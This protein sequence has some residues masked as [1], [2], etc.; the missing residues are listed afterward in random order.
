MHATEQHR[1][2]ERHDERRQLQMRCQYAVDT[3]EQ[4]RDSQHDRRREPRRQPGPDQD[5][6]DDDAH[7][8]QPADRQVDSRMVSANTMP[9]AISPTYVAFCAVE[10]RFPG[11][12]RV[13]TYD[14][15]GSS[16]RGLVAGASQ[17]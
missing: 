1:G 17:P 4:R 2:G 9:H 5:R 3:A 6:A 14:S 8:E 7:R 15:S 12:R 16:T 10:N 13:R 11:R